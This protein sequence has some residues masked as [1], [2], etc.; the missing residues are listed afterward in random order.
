MQRPRDFAGDELDQNHLQDL[1]LSEVNACEPEPRHK[2]C[3]EKMRT[4]DG[5]GR[6][7]EMDDRNGWNNDKKS[8][9]VC[10]KLDQTGFGRLPRCL[11]S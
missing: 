6:R 9:T 8:S 4:E 1:A 5:D 7:I 3:G 2:C 11:N 10:V